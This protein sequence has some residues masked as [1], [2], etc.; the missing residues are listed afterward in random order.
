LVLIL[1]TDQGGFFP[2]GFFCGADGIK[3]YCYEWISVH[4]PQALNLSDPIVWNDPNNGE[5]Y[6]LNLGEQPTNDCW[7]FSTNINRIVSFLIVLFAPFLVRGSINWILKSL[8]ALFKK[9]NKNK[10]T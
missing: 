1:L 5:G 6:C 4:N 8:I 9:N 3:P 2:P 10:K 7:R